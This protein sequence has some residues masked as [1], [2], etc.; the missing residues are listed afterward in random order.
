MATYQRLSAALAPFG[1]VLRGGVQVAD[2]DP[3]SIEYPGDAIETIVLVGNV[4]SS[5]WP[6]FSATMTPHDHPLDIWSKD[7][8]DR[9]AAQFDGQ[10]T[11]PSDGP[12]YFP[13][14]RWAM[15]A[16]PVYPSPVG[17]LIHPDYGLWH[18]YRGAIFFKEGFDIP[19]RGG[20]ANPCLTCADKPCLAACP[21]KAFSDKG[22]S[23]GACFDHLCSDEGKAHCLDRG[24]Q[25]RFPCPI[26]QD[27]RY[28]Q[29]HAAFHIRAFYDARI[30]ERNNQ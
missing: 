23:P 17:V 24:C 1:L 10:A 13:F 29:D 3:D 11:Y 25:T 5:I 27:Y 30:R 6:H 28:E 22:Y 19:E 2:L 18:A 26:G 16:E 9:V 20:Q 21:V 8:I 7:A 15:R 4:G 14:Q 12:P